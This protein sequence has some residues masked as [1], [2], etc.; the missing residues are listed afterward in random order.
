[1]MDT[2][3][4]GLS[5]NHNNHF[6]MGG[7][8]VVSLAKEYG[9][10][11]HIVDENRLRSN[12]HRFYNAFNSSYPEVRVFYSYKTNCI[13][14]L[15]KILHEEGC[16][17]EVVSP[18]ELWIACQLACDPSKIVYNGVNKSEEDLRIAVDRGVGLINVDSVNEIYK[19]KRV[20]S[21][22]KKVVNIGIRIYPGIG[23]KAQFG[24]QPNEDNIIE[25][26]KELD[27]LDYINVS[28]LHVHFG[29]GIKDAG[30][31]LKVIKKICT[32]IKEIKE[33]LNKDI[34][35]LDLGG[36]FGVPTVK[37][38]KIPEMALYKIFNVPLKEPKINHCA[39]IEVFGNEITDFLNKFCKS[40]GLKKPA[41]ILEPGRIITS[42]SQIL[43]IKVV[44]LKTRKNGSNFAI[45]DGGMQNI[46]FPL[47]YEY[48]QCFLANRVGAKNKNRYFI[49]GPLCSPDDILYRNWRLPELKIGDILAIM[50][51]GAYF[52]SF[53][54]NF[55]FARPSIVL[56]SDGTHRLIRREE[57]FE[58]M[59]ELDVI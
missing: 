58:H 15:L 11:L 59:S 4:W 1:M 40:N 37:T 54:N 47:S 13:P 3:H 48:H 43:L 35:Y 30:I 57:N 23:W 24:L 28:C 50:D 51:T 22:L 42:N 56:V 38:I 46:A 20:A 36:G 45:T 5:I 49:T 9:T 34:D 10:P 6:D 26:L 8:D 55:S 2:N 33:Y 29:T 32:L 25:I 12:F 53:S 21:D 31:Y 17:A 41:L 44:D 19:L 7:C 27:G 39:P 52:T 14:A 16:G 18:Y